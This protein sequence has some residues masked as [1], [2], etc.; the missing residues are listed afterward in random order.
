VSHQW[1]VI[2]VIV[3]TAS[4]QHLIQDSSQ[5]ALS[6]SLYKSVLSMIKELK[7]QVLK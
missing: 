1:I 7:K 2:L 4:Q 3:E 6:H 5:V